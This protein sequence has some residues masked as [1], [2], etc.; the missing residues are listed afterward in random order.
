[1][2]IQA[3]N[4]STKKYNSKQLRVADVAGL[5]TM[6]WMA[7]AA[8]GGM[9]RL[10]AYN[11]TLTHYRFTLSCDSVEPNSYGISVT[12]LRPKAMNLYFQ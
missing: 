6:L 5:W 12:F 1:M 4:L 7:G 8:D 2:Y 11:L 3:Q 10:T 9:L